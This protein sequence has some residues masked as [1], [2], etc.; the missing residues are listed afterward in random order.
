MFFYLDPPFFEKADALYRYFFR[1]EDHCALRDTLLQLPD[2]WLLSYDSADQVERLYQSAIA[3]QGNGAK[4][5]DVELL[6]SLSLSRERKRVKEI[7]LST[8]IAR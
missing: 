8:L 3:H 4:R 6:Y 2:K 5:S 7:I 1:Q